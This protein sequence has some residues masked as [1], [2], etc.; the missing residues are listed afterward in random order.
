VYDLAP[1]T[2]DPTGVAG[3][4]VVRIPKRDTGEY[5]YL[6]YRYPVGFDEYIDGTY[7]YA[8]SIHLYKGDGSSTKTRLLSG[9]GDG[10]SFVDSVNG[11][12]VTQIGHYAT[13]STA[14]IEFTTTCLPTPPS[15][16]FSPSTQSGLPGAAASYTLSLTNNDS[17]GC[18]SSAF[19]LTGV[20]PQVWTV[21]LSSANL[22]LGPG[23][24][25]Q[26]AVAV[27]V[28]PSASPGAFEIAVNTTDGLGD[29]HSATVFG[30][31]QVTATC[32]RGTPGIMVSPTTQSSPPGGTLS[33]SFQSSIATRKPVAQVALRS[34]AASQLDGSPRWLL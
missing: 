3:A 13:H 8:L 25:G 16:S 15:M 26:V 22:T 31:Y 23:A 18:P 17:P 4:Q 19:R 20:V 1:L 9:L 5:Y 2:V 33:Y 7:Y 12:K 30:A 32:T 27:G 10:E 34:T 28:A 24:T 11:L 14:L 29:G 21:G 6:S